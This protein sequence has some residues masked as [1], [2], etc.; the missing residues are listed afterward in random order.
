MSVR[1]SSGAVATNPPMMASMTQRR[2]F[3]A[4]TSSKSLPG[5]GALVQLGDRPLAQNSPPRMFRLLAACGMYWQSAYANTNGFAIST[6][7]ATC[8]P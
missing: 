8:M 7:A 2:W 6:N 4:A 1:M 3:S 5:A